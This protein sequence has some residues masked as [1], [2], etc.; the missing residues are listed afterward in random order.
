MATLTLK[1]FK[2]S[3]LA[4]FIDKIITQADVHR[5]YNEARIW[6]IGPDS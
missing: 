1:N 4:N 3:A 2:D 5:D 6:L